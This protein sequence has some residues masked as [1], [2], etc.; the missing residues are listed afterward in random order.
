MNLFNT[1]ADEALSLQP[2]LETL[3]PASPPCGTPLINPATW[4]WILT[5]AH[6]TITGMDRD[7][8]IHALTHILTDSRFAAIRLAILYGSAARDNLRQDSDIDLAVCAGA[9]APLDDG[10]LLDLSESCEIV[11]G[12]DT[13]V[14]DL[15]RARGVFLKEVLTTGVVVH[16]TDP[17]VR[18]ELIVDMLDFVEDLLPVV[19]LVRGRK[20]ERYLAG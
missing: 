17:R 9:R 6:A 20:R 14:R 1:L 12:R 7:G 13:Q 16:Q 15:S 10:I 2:G 3:R 11:T 5:R 19:R 18:G 4:L 8:I